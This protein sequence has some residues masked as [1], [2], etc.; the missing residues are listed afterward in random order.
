MTKLSLVTA[1]GREL[2]YGFIKSSHVSVEVFTDHLLDR[3]RNLIDAATHLVA[4]ALLALLVLLALQCAALHYGYSDITLDLPLPVVW[5]WAIFIVGLV[6]NVVA[7]L[8][9]V[10]QAWHR[11]RTTVGSGPGGFILVLLL[12][13]LRVPVAIALALVGTLGAIWLGGWG[14]P[15]DRDEPVRVTKHGAGEETLYHRARYLSVHRG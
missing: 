5:C 12:N 1:A 15:S 14:Y 8:W 11:L 2:P 3:A 6:L 13:V 7:C 4:A 9:R 10:G